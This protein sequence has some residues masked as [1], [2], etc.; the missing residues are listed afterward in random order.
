TSLVQS[1][2]PNAPLPPPASEDGYSYEEA[3]GI[4]GRELPRGSVPFR[5]FLDPPNGDDTIGVI[6]PSWGLDN[7]PETALIDRDGN[8]RAHFVNKRDGSSPV[9]QTCIRAVLDEK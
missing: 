5:V 2:K 6:A 9:A 7:V 4:Y 1:L 3:M 8:I